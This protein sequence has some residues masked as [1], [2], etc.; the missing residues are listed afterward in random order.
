VSLRTDQPFVGR[1]DEL[2][3]RRGGSP[4]GQTKL[5]KE[6]GLANNTVA[7]GWTE[8]LADLLCVGLSPA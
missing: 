1:A 7:A 3:R 8:L 2:L 4:V 5:A 6:A